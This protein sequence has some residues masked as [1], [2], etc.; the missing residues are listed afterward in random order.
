M[1]QSPK[2]IG[3]TYSPSG[4]VLWFKCPVDVGNDGDMFF[5]DFAGHDNLPLPLDLI[6]VPVME[7]TGGVGSERIMFYCRDG[8]KFAFKCELPTTVV[9]D[10]QAVV[11]IDGVNVVGTTAYDRAEFVISYIYEN[12]LNYVI[13]T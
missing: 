6:G 5:E 1:P 3:L 9:A 12:I 11:S 8:R 13:P 10:D 2:E 7:A 4:K